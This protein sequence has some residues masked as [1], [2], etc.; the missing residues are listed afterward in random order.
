MKILIRFVLASFELS[1]QNNTAGIEM[2]FWDFFGQRPISL[3]AYLDEVG[4]TST[5]KILPGTR[6]GASWLPWHNLNS[7]LWRKKATQF[8]PWKKW[9]DDFLHSLKLKIIS[10]MDGASHQ[11]KYNG[12]PW[13]DPETPRYFR[14]LEPL[15]PPHLQRKNTG[16]C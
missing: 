3:E 6:N 5:W 11:A 12:E 14:P 9:I 2:W 15:D 13:D 4:P 1:M 7:C 10:C 8:R 16:V